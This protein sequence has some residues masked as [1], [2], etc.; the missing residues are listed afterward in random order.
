MIINN[1]WDQADNKE[2]VQI[3]RALNAML[4]ALMPK[5]VLARCKRFLRRHCRKPREMKV[6]EY[7]HYLLQMNEEEFPS[8]PPFNNNQGLP[9]DEILDILLFGTPKSWEREMDKQGFDRF[10]TDLN[11]VVSNLKLEDKYR[12]G[13][14][15]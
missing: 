15:L 4:T 13:R 7:V 2:F 9:E 3:G 8:L 12:N 10:S 5:K 14:R 6:R 1:G 11:R